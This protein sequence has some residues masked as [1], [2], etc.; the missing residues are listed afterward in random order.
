MTSGL[1]EYIGINMIVS[2]ISLID[3]GIG[4]SEV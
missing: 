2:P 1:P 4:F 3:V